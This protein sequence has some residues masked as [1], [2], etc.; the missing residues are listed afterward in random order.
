MMENNKEEIKA[1]MLIINKLEKKK[2]NE[3]KRNT[4]V[5]MKMMSNKNDVD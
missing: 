1:K 5:D 3:R 2:K 4:Q